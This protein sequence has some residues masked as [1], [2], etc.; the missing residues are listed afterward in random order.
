MVTS[1]NRPRFPA[2]RRTSAATLTIEADDLFAIETAVR[3]LEAMLGIARGK[4]TA[5]ARFLP[6][7]YERGVRRRSALASTLVAGL[8]LAKRGEIQLRQDRAF[9]PIFIRAGRGGEEAAD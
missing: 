5:L 6:P 4:W 9:G 8:E 2:R 7:G 3:R 1:R